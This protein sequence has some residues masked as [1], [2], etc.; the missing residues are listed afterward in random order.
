LKSETCIKS[1]NKIEEK[2]AIN[3]ENIQ[4][5]FNIELN[6]LT[7]TTI[8]VKLSNWNVIIKKN[9]VLFTPNE[10]YLKNCLILRNTLTIIDKKK[11]P[12]QIANISEKHIN[13]KSGKVLVFLN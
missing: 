8:Y 7:I 12:I 4:S 5:V 9:A 11:I 10:Y 13:I 3:K 6:P 2:K 1:D